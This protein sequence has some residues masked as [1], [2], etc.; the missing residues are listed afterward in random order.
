MKIVV[1]PNSDNSRPKLNPFI[2]HGANLKAGQHYS[3]LRV[4]GT[5]FTNLN[6]LMPSDGAG[7]FICT[8]ETIETH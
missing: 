3:V 4:D 6:V 7:E 8:A 5:L 2:L 1:K